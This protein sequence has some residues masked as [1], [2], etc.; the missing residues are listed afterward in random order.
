M[1]KSIEPQIGFNVLSDAKSYYQ[2]VSQ[3]YLA[4]G[5]S[6][7]KFMSQKEYNII[8]GMILTKE[9]LPT[10]SILLLN[11]TIFLTK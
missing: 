7:S 6:L 5:Y 3:G 9:D 8:D 1:E 10:V 4:Q 11:Q 2:S